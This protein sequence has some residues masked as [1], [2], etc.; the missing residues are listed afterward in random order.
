MKII[1]DYDLCQGHGACMGEAPQL[2]RVDDKGMLTILQ[3]TPP[4]GLRKQLESA[5]KYCPTGAIRIEG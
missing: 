1:V 2:F 3:E 4:E 5:A